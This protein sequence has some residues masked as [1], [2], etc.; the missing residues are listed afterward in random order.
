M[1]SFHRKMDINVQDFLSCQCACLEINWQKCT[2]TNFPSANIFLE[3]PNNRQ[4][5]VP[6][7]KEV[8]FMFYNASVLFRNLPVLSSNIN[9]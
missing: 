3:I 2:H 9:T 6:L 7:E 4:D 1:H 8:I 5:A